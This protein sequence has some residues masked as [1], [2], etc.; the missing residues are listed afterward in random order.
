MDNKITEI[1][2]VPKN[3]AINADCFDI[4]KMIQDKSIDLIFCDLPY[5]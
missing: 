5:G 3:I 4:M 1:G 2:F